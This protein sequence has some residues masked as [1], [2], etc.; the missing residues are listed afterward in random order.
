MVYNRIMSKNADRKAVM[1]ENTGKLRALVIALFCV[2]VIASVVLFSL[3]GLTGAKRYAGTET[4]APTAGPTAAPTAEPTPLPADTPEAT[5]EPAPSDTP[6]PQSYVRTAIIIDGSSFI[7]LASRQAAEE[8]I[9]SAVAH[10]ERLCPGTGMVTELTSEVEYAAAE[11]AS[12][13]TSFDE[14]YSMLIGES[15]PLR[16]RTTFARDAIVPIPNKT[17]YTSSD[18]Y[19][20]GTRFVASYGRKGK[21]LF[22]YEYTYL[23]GEEYYAAIT[24]ERLLAEPIDEHIIIGTRPIGPNVTD[25]N[26]LL[27]ECPPAPFAFVLPVQGS[28]SRF[29]GYYE[30]QFHRG[31]D[32]Q[33]PEGT[34]CLAAASGTVVAVIERGTLGLTVDI[35]HGS[36]FITRYAGLDR[37][38]V[39]VGELIAMGAP[40]GRLGANGLHF[41]VIAG[42]IP[43]N[44]LA[45]IHP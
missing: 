34:E 14:A 31:V 16:V 18:L 11:D 28:V 32:I 13:A 1:A 40:I 39:T 3:F 43:K 41:E 33:A 10:F 6:E 21:K 8:V 45:Y 44:P 20:V 5:E 37:A 24:E 30:A 26:Y 36:G 25:G 29:F 27:E 22:V 23:N 4:P 35:D 42:G 7:V 12:N 9:A 38:E 19:T 17:E 2:L 15:T